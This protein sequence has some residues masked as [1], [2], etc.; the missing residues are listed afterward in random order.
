M[1]K[2]VFVFNFFR[3]SQTKL[4]KAK[5]GGERGI[6]TLASSFPDSCLAGKRFKPLSHLSQQKFHKHEQNKDIWPI[7][8]VQLRR[9][10]HIFLDIVG[11]P[12]PENRGAMAVIIEIKVVPS[13]GRTGCKLEGTRLKC[14]LK[15]PPEKGK[16]NKELVSYL[17]KKLKLSSRDITIMTGATSP[18]KRV[19]VETEKS[20]DEMCDDLGI[21]R[22][23]TIF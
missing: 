19:K 15:S 17:A 20:F 1:A 16:A 5:T 18:L 10:L 6:R 4:V 7:T 12:K 8:Q 21:E 9:L 2:P 14:F 23:I 13:S 11:W 3:R 22:Q